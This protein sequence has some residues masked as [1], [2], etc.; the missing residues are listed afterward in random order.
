MRIFG[1]S[2]L[3]GCDDQGDSARLLAGRSIEH[4]AGFR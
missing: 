3:A 4:R 1:R 2:T